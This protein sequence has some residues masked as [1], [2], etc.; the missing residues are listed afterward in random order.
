MFYIIIHSVLSLSNLFL[1]RLPIFSSI[2]CSHGFL[3]LLHLQYIF[4]VVSFHLTL[5]LCSPCRLWGLFLLLLVSVTGCMRSVQGLV[6]GFPGGK[7]WLLCPQRW[8]CILSLI[9]RATSKGVY[10]GVFRT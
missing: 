7:D 1:G 6:Q 8:S 4:S 9:D 5:F 3:L 2:I 10:L